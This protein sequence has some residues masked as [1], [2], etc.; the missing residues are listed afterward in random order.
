MVHPP[1]CSSLKVLY[2]LQMLHD[3]SVTLPLMW[4][5]WMW[6]MWIL[7]ELPRQWCEC[8]LT[9]AVADQLL[10]AEGWLGMGTLTIYMKGWL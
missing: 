3:C 6:I 5:L 7:A 8:P 10:P 4:I 9:I 2:C 1:V